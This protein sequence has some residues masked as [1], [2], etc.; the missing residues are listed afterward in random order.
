M[1]MMGRYINELAEDGERNRLIVEAIQWLY[2]SGRDVLIVSDRIEQLCNLMALSRAVGLPDKDMGLYARYREVWAYVKNPKPPRIP[3]DA[4]PD[5]VPM[6]WATERKKVTQQELDEV[7]GSKRLIYATYKMFEKGVDLPRLDGGVDC[8]P[9]SRA[10]QV[11]GRILRT[12][13]DKKVPIW[14]TIRDIWSFRAE[15]QFLRRLDDYTNSN[16]EVYLWQPDKGVRKEDVDALAMEVRARIPKLKVQQITTRFDGSYTLP[17]L[18]TL[19]D[20]AAQRGTPTARKTRS[21][22]AS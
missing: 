18:T 11:H 5:Y 7:I 9:H 19:T 21:R 17:I 15:V 2:K 6:H 20:S 16:A 22:Q 13:A 14:V 1:K 8:T 12:G 10:T 4:P 3:K